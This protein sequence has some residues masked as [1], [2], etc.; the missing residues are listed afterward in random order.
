MPMP[1]EPVKC[2][3]QNISTGGRLADNI[4]YEGDLS[5]CKHTI[6]L[7]YAILNKEHYDTLFNATQQTYLNGGD[8]FLNITIPTY[9]PEGL[10]SFKVYFMSEHDPACTQ[11]TEREYYRTGDSRY[12]I[13]GALYDELH[14]NVEFSFVEK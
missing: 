3:P 6:T 8:F 10:K 5:G 4:D 12:N 14:E 11:T 1:S 13:G 7:K 9:T 2:K